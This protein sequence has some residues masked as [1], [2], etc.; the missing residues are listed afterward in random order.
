MIKICKKCGTEFEVTKGLINY[1]SSKCVHSRGERSEDVKLQISKSIIIHY[2]SYGTKDFLSKE[3]RLNIK[4]IIE[5]KALDKILSTP[6]EELSI[7]RLKKLIVHEQSNKC[8]RCGL[9]SWNDK[10]L[11]LELDHIDGNN[12]NNVRE[13]LRCLCPNCHSQTDT[14]RGRNS[15]KHNKISDE[16]IY[17]ALL[18]NNWNIHK[19]LLAIGLAPKGGNYKRCYRINRLHDE[20]I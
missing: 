8:N 2:S 12:K 13:N 4:K 9:N 5:Q 11:V 15:K 19:T 14:W 20:N 7:E 6:I 17:N 10:P 16:I 3:T 18:T 1:C